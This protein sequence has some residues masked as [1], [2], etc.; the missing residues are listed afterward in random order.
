MN[1]KNL[2]NILEMGIIE[3]QHQ[4]PLQQ[5]R[6][7]QQQHTTDSLSI[8]YIQLKEADLDRQTT[9]KRKR[10][11]QASNKSNVLSSSNIL[12]IMGMHALMLWMLHVY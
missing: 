9:K 10:G 8:P 2:L 6:E 5:N 1:H 12:V 3:H 11:K 4:Q 7:Q